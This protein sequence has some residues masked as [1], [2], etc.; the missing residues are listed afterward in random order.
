[1]LNTFP[2]LL[3]LG[4]FAPFILRVSVGLVFLLFGYNKLFKNRTKI[5]VALQENPASLL[6]LKQHIVIL[7]IFVVWIFGIVEI[8]VGI[9]FIVG[10][11]TQIASLVSI[12]IILKTLY[13][14]KHCPLFAPHSPL[15]Y[16][17]LI[18]I[19]LS[20]LISGAGALAFDLPL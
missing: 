8:L 2:D 1:M 11:L 3:I 13:F 5:I 4:F 18:A 17:L 19:S 10:Y 14:R 16:I 7:S 20:L 6:F 9:F 12:V 15:A